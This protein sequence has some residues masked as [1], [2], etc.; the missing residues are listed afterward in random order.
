MLKS[1]IKRVCPYVL[2]FG[3]LSAAVVDLDVARQVARGIYF[4]YSDLH[5]GNVFNVSEVEIITD[6]GVNLIYIFHLYPQGF[7]IVPADDRAVPSL[8]F[9][10]DAQ[11]DTDNMPPNLK[12][13]IDQYKME[14]HEAIRLDQ[15]IP[16]L[17]IEEEWIRYIS[18]DINSNR[19]RDVS[20]L[21]SA[22]FDQSGSWNNG[23]TQAIGF[24]GP[25]GC[26]AVA[27][28]QV[29]HYWEY[30]ESGFGSNF[31]TEDDYGYIEVDFEDAFYDFDNMAATYGTAASQLLLFHAGVAV[32]MDYSN[33]GSGAQ[34]VGSYPS[35][36][37]AMEH[38]FGYSSDVAYEWK[39]N[40]TTSEYRNIIKNEL[41]NNR[42]LIAKGYGS[43]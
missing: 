26:V 22:E 9:G 41:D 5:D 19:S 24:N 7:I 8:A 35:A 29:M 1:T 38:F 28:A 11:F 37:Y 12:A 27:M 30:P 20:P 4:D 23:V 39:D 36:F 13:V 6:E 3:V 40:H 42:P 10:F 21:M 14:L 34:V 32:N 17:E 43:S 33:S 2:I 31:Y 16:N 25:V 15:T 18:G